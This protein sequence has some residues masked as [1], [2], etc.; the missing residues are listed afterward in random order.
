[1]VL[2]TNLAQREKFEALDDNGN[3]KL[4][5]SELKMGIFRFRLYVCQ[6]VAYMCVCRMLVMNAKM[7][8]TYVITPL[9][10]RVY[11]SMHSSLVLYGPMNR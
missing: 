3:G 2:G 7:W 4:S 9:T 1:M 11:L 8:P 5:C 6:P 10:W